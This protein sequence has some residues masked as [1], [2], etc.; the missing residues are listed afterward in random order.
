MARSRATL[1]K[2]VDEA[3]RSARRS[4]GAGISLDEITAS[5]VAGGVPCLRMRPTSCLARSRAN[6]RTCSARRLASADDSGRHGARETG[7]EATA[8]WRE[9]EWSAACGSATRA[10]GPATMKTNG[11]AGST[12]WMPELAQA[13]P[14]GLCA[15]GEAGGIFRRRTARHGWL[16][17]GAGSACHDVRQG[18]RDFQ[19][20]ICWTAPT[21][22]RSAR[23]SDRSSVIALHRFVEIRKHDRAEHLLAYFHHPLSEHRG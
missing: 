16:Q 14:S 20:S 1:E 8:A 23:G 13:W 17:P 7:G 21:R 4:R 15:G 9:A 12:A 22:L 6:A 11:S 2:N 5:L 10:C 3:Q 18:R 19:N